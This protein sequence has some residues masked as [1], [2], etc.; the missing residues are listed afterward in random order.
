MFGGDECCVVRAAPARAAVCAGAIGVS[1][2]RG[3]TG[4]L[5]GATPSAGDA[6]RRG[7]PASLAEGEPARDAFPRS[8]GSAPRG[9]LRPPRSARPRSSCRGRQGRRREHPAHPQTR[10]RPRRASPVRDRNSARF[11]GRI[12][13]GS[14]WAPQARFHERRPAPG[15]RRERAVQHH[16]CRGVLCDGTPIGGASTPKPSH[17][18]YGVDHDWTQPHHEDEGRTRRQ[19][20]GL[21]V[22]GT[23]LLRR[24]EQRGSDHLVGGATPLPAYGAPHPQHPATTRA[25]SIGSAHAGQRSTT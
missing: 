14:G 12:A 5:G 3:T 11:P 19:P 22:D 6:L 4:C 18:A 2:G 15:Y 21:L 10:R 8:R 20:R 23:P 25:R 24:F 16:G 9:D 1:P 13:G 17:P 7:L